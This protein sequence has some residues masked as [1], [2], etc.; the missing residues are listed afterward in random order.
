MN[1][2]FWTRSIALGA[3]LLGLAAC[4]ESEPEGR[5]SDLGVPVAGSTI[6][7]R[8]WPKEGPLAACD[9][10]VGTIYRY[11]D[12]RWTVDD[13]LLERKGKSWC[14]QTTLPTDCAFMALKFRSAD[15]GSWLWDTN[16]DQ[17]FVY[18]T[19]DSLG[20]RLPGGDLA[21]GVFR[22][23]KTFGIANY[24]QDFDISAEALE[25]WVTKEIQKH[26]QRLPDFLEYYLKMVELRAGENYGRALPQIMQQYDEEFGATERSMMAF[27]NQFRFVLRDEHRA[28]SIHRELLRRYPQS[29]IAM[30]DALQRIERMQGGV[31]LTELKQFLRRYPRA[32]HSNANQQLY[33]RCYRLLGNG[34]FA[35]KRYDELLA[36][37]PDMDFQSISE[38][39]RWNVFGAVKRRNIATE[40][41]LPV[42]EA[43]YAEL[44]KKADDG[45]TADGVRLTP[46]EVRQGITRQIDDRSETQAILLERAEKYDAAVEAVSRI[47]TDGLYAGSRTCGLKYRLLKQVGR[48]AEA[49]SVCREAAARNVLSTEMLADMEQAYEAENGSKQGFEEYLYGL[50]SEATRRALECEVEHHLLDE[51]IEPFALFDAKG[52]L[53]HSESWGDKIVVIDFWA[54]WCGPCQAAFPGMQIAVDRHKKEKNVLFL[55]VCTQDKP[56]GEELQARVDRCV[57]QKGYDFEVCYDQTTNDASHTGQAFRQFAKRFNSSGIPRKVI[58][59]KGRLRY[60][61]EGYS[62]SPSKLAD[63]I[64]YAVKHI[65]NEKS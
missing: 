38:L 48:A 42:A 60:T 6:D 34:L 23:G 53:V 44:L 63:E 33:Y 25:M 18:V 29:T 3:V 21:W 12:Y 54:T 9:S 20:N 40:E 8:Y 56:Y 65:K 61:S 7:V 39:Y 2:K 14:G 57:T 19:A 32:P 55:F 11:D 49:A 24:F 13:V 31:L 35:A 36:L 10:I 41:L 1:L 16:D 64:T 59:H 50:Q 45:S 28:D 30:R 37:L 26:E 47:S 15:A 46:I 43:L 4:G 51:S 52:N 5:L 58:L 17:G 27:Y 22:K 62:G